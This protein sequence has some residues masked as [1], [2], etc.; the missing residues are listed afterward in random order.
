MVKSGR[1]GAL[2]AEPARQQRDNESQDRAP[3]QAHKHG[4][5]CRDD[6]LLQMSLEELNGDLSE[7][8]VA[9]TR[10]PS[11]NAVANATRMAILSSIMPYVS[12]LRAQ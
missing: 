9:V 3:D 11:S 4:E 12:W 10:M 7:T 8:V 2:D 6:R 1:G 5:D